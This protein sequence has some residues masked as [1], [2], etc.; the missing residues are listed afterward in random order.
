MIVPTPAAGALCGPVLVIEAATSA[1]SVALLQRIEA[2][3]PWS[4]LASV[5]VPMGSGS[6]D[7]LTPA[8]SAVCSAA[9]VP[10]SALSAVVC[11][12]GPG[13]FTSLRI[14]SA[15]AKGLA[16]GLGRPLYAIP[17]LLLAASV[18]TDAPPP[19]SSVLVVLDAL[20]GECFTQSVQI[21]SDGMVRLS[22]ALR[23]VPR[24]EL[25]ALARDARVL[26]VDAARGVSPQAAAA[27][28]C[29][30]WDAFGPCDI[31][32]WEPEY[33]RLAEA[34]VKWEAAHGRTLPAT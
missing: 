33:G 8:V 19:A 14:A 23:R 15:L 20:R 12:G 11:G 26:E 4:L 28:W 7:H 32:T 13:S 22:G 17:S 1:G 6:D 34:Q 30:P 27:R 10:V 25:I 3:Q 29:A 2:A 31:D 16:F 5:D 18:V 24:G 21:G 9:A